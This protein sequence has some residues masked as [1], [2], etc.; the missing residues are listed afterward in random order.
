MLYC[1]VVNG[2]VETV[3]MAL[4]D[5]L[6]GKTEEELIELG[7]YKATFNNMPHHLMGT[8]NELTQYIEMQST[9]VNNTV[10]CTYVVL[11][12]TPEMIELTATSIMDYVRME[13]NNRL[14]VCDWT[15]LSDAPLTTEQKTAWA[16]YRQTLRDFPSVVQLDNIIWPTQPV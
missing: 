1:N 13:R 9:I 16:T 2:N 7:W 4:L 10:E 15:Q 3:P 5:E 12:K 8:Y 11:D 6:K 14:T